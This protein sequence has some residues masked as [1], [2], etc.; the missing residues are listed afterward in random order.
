MIAGPVEATALGN[1]LMQLMS[2]RDIRS[3][4]E[5]REIVR[6]SFP[7]K[8]YTPKSTAAWDEAFARYLKIEG[9]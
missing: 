1:I 5:A 2:T 9:R 8:S 6:E 4:D 7:T 3:L